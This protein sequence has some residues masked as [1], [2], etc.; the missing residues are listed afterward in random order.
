MLFSAGSSLP[1]TMKV[2]AHWLCEVL[3]LCTEIPY[4]PAHP[5][6]PVIKIKQTFLS[7][8]LASSLVFE[9]M[10]LHFLVACTFLD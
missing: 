8:N 6:L 3:G 7:T 2:L 4:F 5:G 1:P 10:D 9:Q